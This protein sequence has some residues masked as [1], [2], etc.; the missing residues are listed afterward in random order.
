MLRTVRSLALSLALLAVCSPARAYECSAQTGGHR[1]ALLELYT[2]EGC[3]SCPPADH[4]LSTLET[5]SALRDRVVPLALHVDYWDYIGWRDPYAIALHTQRQ[6][7]TVTKS[8][9]EIVYTPQFLLNG[10]DFRGWQRDRL[11]RELDNLAR[12]PA[13]AELM[14]NA[15]GTNASSPVTVTLKGQ[16]RERHAHAELF[17]VWYEN[18]LSS[19]V[20][21][22]EN[23]GRTLSH[24]RVVRDWLSG[25]LKPAA[26][27]SWI[28]T[29]NAVVPPGWKRADL[30]LAAF[31]QDSAT[32]EILQALA[33]PLCGV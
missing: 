10:R 6:R 12:Q 11:I 27:G 18:R 5:N 32:G 30:G 1:I 20:R 33:L 26:D 3:N 31:V 21:A 14:I 19:A 29:R 16:L 23:S 9:G 28:L 7:A 15:R 4:W 13:P 22:G 25:P 24:E 2:S 17:F 8:G